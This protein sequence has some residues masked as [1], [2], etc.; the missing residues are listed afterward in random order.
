MDVSG[1]QQLDVAHTL[2]RKRISDDGA[3]ISSE[4]VTGAS[5][6]ASAPAELVAGPTCMAPIADLGSKGPVN[7][8]VEGNATEPLCGSCYGAESKQRPCCNTCEDVR[9]AYR[10]KGWAFTDADGVAQVLA[11]RRE[12]RSALLPRPTRAS[13][14]TA[15]CKQEGWLDRIKAMINEGCNVFGYIEVNKV[16]GNFHFAPG[17]SFQQ[18]H[19][20]VHDLQAFKVSYFNTSHTIHR[21]SFGRDYPGLVNPLD[22]TKK[23]APPAVGSAM[24]QYFIKIVPTTYRRLD[25]EEVRTNQFSA[26]QHFKAI[27]HAA[28]DYGLP[29]T[30]GPDARPR[31]SAVL[32]DADRCRVSRSGR[33]C[34]R[35][36]S[37]TRLRAPPLALAS[38]TGV[39]F[40]YDLSPIMVQITESRS[41]IAVRGGVPGNRPYARCLR[42]D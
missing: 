25:G 38:R 27:N 9:E 17:K 19:A 28:G 20:H 30:C 32:A 33:R 13:R 21:L 15:Q 24:Y 41:S 35:R 8:S 16:A 36:D 42:P 10:S 22:G 18:Q 11:G 6:W 26:T 1:E 23:I 12:G 4:Q 29:G 40:V 3:P 37:C 31:A 39:F 7:V 14:R 34:I 2:F 5:A